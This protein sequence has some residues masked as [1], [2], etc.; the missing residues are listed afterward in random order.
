MLIRLTE[1]IVNVVL[2]Y[3]VTKLIAEK[4]TISD[5]MIDGCAELPFTEIYNY[6][7]YPEVTDKAGCLLFSLIRFHPY[8]DGCKRTALL[9]TMLFLFY[10]GT[11][12]EIPE[13]SA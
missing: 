9:S 12:F 13:D 2:D 1:N 5:G 11:V 4:G 6:A 10:N 8:I 3:V 7:P